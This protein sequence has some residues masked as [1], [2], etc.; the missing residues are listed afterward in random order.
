L[1]GLAGLGG[2]GGEMFSTGGGAV[3]L[4]PEE[5]AVNQNTVMQMITNN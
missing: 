4:L 2:G 3:C 5:Q 1:A